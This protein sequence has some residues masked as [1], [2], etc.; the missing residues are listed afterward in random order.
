MKRFCS[1]F[2]C[3]LFFA[4]MFMTGCGETQ[5]SKAD[6][7]A[8]M[9]ANAGRCDA[10]I[11]RAQG[12][13]YMIDT[14]LKESAPKVL[15]ALDCMQVDRL[16]AVFLTHT[17]KDHIGGLAAV[18][19]RYEIGCV[20]AAEI[21]HNKKDGSNAITEL[22]AELGLHLRRLKAGEAVKT[23][24]SLRFEVIG[25]LEYNEDDDNDNSLVLSLRVNGRRLLFA[26]D[27]QF[28]EEKSL[29]RGSVPLS[30]DVLKVGNHGNPDATGDSFAAAVSPELAFI[31]TDTQQDKNSANER[32]VAAL[33]NNGAKIVLSEQFSV[34]ALLTIAQDGAMNVSDPPQSAAE[35]KLLLS[36]PDREQQAITVSNIGE[37]A[38]QLQ[39]FF[40]FSERN[41]EIFV[42]PSYLLK[43]GESVT[44]S[45]TAVGDLMWPLEKVF[46]KKKSNPTALYN[47]AGNLICRVEGE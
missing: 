22:T 2:F 29:M 43:P 38:V 44:V 14:G 25:P 13:F 18:A 6:D 35:E 39:N 10:I 30:A 21:S 42:F 31:T 46:G 20:Y 33:K 23:G 24:D 47:A 26:G 45:C 12:K 7:F 28:A 27:M 36:E 19:Q 41:S 4:C 16:T 3:L 8:V 1:G 32:V 37:N 5:D 17:H 11:V 9:F 15:R 40:L 34:G